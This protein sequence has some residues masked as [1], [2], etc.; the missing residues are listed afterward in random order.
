MYLVALTGYGQAA[1]RARA[2]DA[3]F[4]EHLV[5]PVSPES[6]MRLLARGRDATN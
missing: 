3:G 2:L 1:D 6:L 5:K 4:D